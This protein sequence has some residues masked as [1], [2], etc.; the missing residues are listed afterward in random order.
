MLWLTHRRLRSSNPAKRLEAVA[1][2][3]SSPSQAATDALGEALS[4]WDD[5][6]LRLA[7]A[8]AL[9]KSSNR[10]SAIDHL[11]SALSLEGD[12]SVCAVEADALYQLGW[13]EQVIPPDAPIVLLEKVR[14][15]ASGPAQSKGLQTLALVQD[16][17]RQ[18]TI[19]ARDKL[20]TQ[21]LLRTEE[22]R[23]HLEAGL[24]EKLDAINPRCVPVREIA[25]VGRVGSPIAIPW[26]V[27]YLIARDKN[28]RDE[29]RRALQAIDSNWARSPNLDAAVSLI[30]KRALWDS[31]LEPVLAELGV[32]VGEAC[33]R[34]LSGDDYKIRAAALYKLAK[35]KDD[36]SI[37]AA[38]R[39][40]GDPIGNVIVAAIKTLREL[41]YEPA[42]N[43]ISGL[44]E[45]CFLDPDSIPSEI[46]VYRGNDHTYY[47]QEESLRA[48]RA[49]GGEAALSAVMMGA[50]FESSR[51]R[52]DAVKASSELGP[53]SPEVLTLL[54]KLAK[55]SSE[56]IRGAVATALG[57]YRL[58]D[59][60]FP[61]LEALLDDKEP[62]VR[63]AACHALTRFP[64]KHHFP[65]AAFP[66]LQ[67]L[68][69]DKEPSV[70]EAACEALIR[71]PDKSVPCL[72]NVLSKYVGSAVLALTCLVTILDRGA[73]LVSTKDLLALVCLTNQQKL[74]QWFPNNDN[75]PSY[76][77]EELDCSRLR[78]L[79][80]QELIKRGQAV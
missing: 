31:S 29:A 47:M 15:F 49:L 9:A 51:I 44:L 32:S 35:V 45:R 7:A 56:H 14:D 53:S 62:F 79:A 63:S 23:S 6:A 30:A 43:P 42:A 19:K 38:M 12:A 22:L 59:A 64:E 40:L 68:S 13:F 78:Q 67:K 16:L 28:A 5:K 70:R 75:C 2:L 48:L 71:F 3:K 1:A 39:A 55:D 36:R 4:N 20:E 17:E 34:L 11:V 61:V 27:P 77:S 25:E 41:K 76:K 21:N 8:L 50:E 74:T 72:T 80:R 37:D 65:D 60:A 73:T 46:G 33:M 54:G 24:E 66:A 57:G 10:R 58:P 26:L 52:I 18:A 69:D